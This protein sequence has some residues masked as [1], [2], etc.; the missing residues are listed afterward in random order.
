LKTPLKLAIP[1]II[2]VLIL[3]GTVG[4]VEA[5]SIVKVTLQPEV[6]EVKPG[7]QFKV[8]IHIDPGGGGV[9]AGEFVVS[10]PADVFKSVDVKLGEFF[11]ENPLV[12][13]KEVKL[14]GGSE[15][16][17]VAVARVGETLKP[18]PPGIALT[19]TLKVLEEASE[20]D[21]DISLVKADLVN[22]EFQRISNIEVEEC[23]IKVK[24]PIT[25]TPTE[26]TTTTTTTTT[27]PPPPTT[28]TTTP[29]TTTMP[30]P[31][32][33]KI[34]ITVL[35]EVEGKPL[36]NV[37][38]EVDGKQG[39]TDIDGKAV[40]IVEEGTYTV[41]A[42]LEGYQDR[43]VKV[44]VAPG[45][46]TFVELRL[47]PLQ[48]AGGGCL[49]ATA[50][51]GGELTPQVQILRN[52][53][54][55]YVMATRGGLAFMNVFNLWYYSWSPTVAELERQIPPL[56]EA[57]KGLIYPLLF[58]LEAARKVYQLLSFT[59][60]AAILAAGIL[61][62]ILIAVSYLALPALLTSLKFKAGTGSL[63]KI[64]SGLLLTLVAIHLVGL[65]AAGW[66]LTLTSPAIVLTT[67]ALTFILM[68][69]GFGRLKRGMK[70][71]QA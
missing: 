56:K 6:S 18:T 67:M 59:P 33:A 54:D 23:A 22:E 44:T 49:I 28:T 31:P 1:L 61:V 41:K 58:E 34:L 66:L 53:R 13:V 62:S 26:T 30:P 65:K 68:V 42:S 38:V 7:D 63:T 15:K 50:A 27:S 57:V 39:F 71:S 17:R 55:N 43:T 29:A 25:V 40:F 35:D 9:S 12:A 19:I 46:E 8:S 11:G 16:V 36:E 70:P 24:L 32:P 52:F 3:A 2:T 60:E 5:G 64:F 4:F 45:E 20:G 51:F 48:K 10:Y 69:E 14:E 21:Y 37:R 47:K